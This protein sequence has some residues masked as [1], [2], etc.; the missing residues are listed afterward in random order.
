MRLDEIRSKDDADLAMMLAKA[1]REMFDLRFKA[2]TGEVEDPNA[3]REQRRSIARILTI[4]N[5]RRRGIRGARA[6]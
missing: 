1:R 2:V 6:H 4:Q 3:F 5:E